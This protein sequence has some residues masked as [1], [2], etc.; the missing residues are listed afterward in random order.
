MYTL[1]GLTSPKTQEMDLSFISNCLEE[2][3]RRM[4]GACACS[5]S[6]PAPNP[7]MWTT[8][9]HLKSLLVPTLRKR[10]RFV[11]R[12]HT[13]WADLQ[14]Y[15]LPV[16]EDLPADDAKRKL[17]APVGPRRSLHEVIWALY[18]IT[19]ASQHHCE[20]VLSPNEVIA[21]IDQLIKSKHLSTESKSRLSVVR[22]IFA[23]YSHSLKVPGFSFIT[24]APRISLRERLD[25]ILADAYLLEASHLRRFLGLNANAKA[26]QRDLRKLIKFIVNNRPWAKGIL[27]ASTQLAQ[28]PA[29]PTD[30]AGL[31]FDAISTKV[32]DPS[33]PLLIDPI[34]FHKDTGGDSSCHIAV[35]HLPAMTKDVLL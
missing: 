2:Y 11:D 35:S 30:A 18:M 4:I 6:I 9:R 14:A 15:L 19:L 34:A 5:V 1:A 7:K 22:G 33:A 16:F 28:L 20:V 13:I 3:L 32:T 21:I 29:I 8:P 24:K 23:L 12:R 10:M 26:I 31:I 27:S 17:P 25:E